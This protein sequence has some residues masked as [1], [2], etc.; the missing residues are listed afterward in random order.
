MNRTIS[1][2]LLLFS[3][4]LSFSSYA[5]PPEAALQ[6]ES[7][8][9]QMKEILETHGIGEVR[10]K[11][12]S[13]AKEGFDLLSYREP[14]LEANSGPL[15]IEVT[16]HPKSGRFVTYANEQLRKTGI[17]FIEYVPVFDEKATA[18][19]DPLP[20]D[21][22][23]DRAWQ[24][25]RGALIPMTGFLAVLWQQGALTDLSSFSFED[26]KLYADLS[27]AM[28]VFML[29]MQFALFSHKWAKLW[30]QDQNFNLQF[31]MLP[32]NAGISRSVNRI[33]KLLNKISAATINRIT[34]S[35]VYNFVVNWGYAL[36]L[37]SVGVFAGQALGLTEHAW[38][39]V[40]LVSKSGVMT[41]AFYLAFG[42]D[43]VA[44]AQLAGRGEVSAH[45]RF[46][47]ETVAVFWNNFWRVASALPGLYALGLGMQLSWGALV[48]LPLYVKLARL[49]KMNEKTRDLFI[50]NSKAPAAATITCEG[51]F[52]P[53]ALFHRQ[54]TLKGMGRV[55]MGA[56]A[57]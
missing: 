25:V 2:F 17:D 14:I 26:K 38:S 50:A 24:K 34:P 37:Y 51:A 45:L 47:I 9:S 5:Q 6:L 33:V 15:K 12:H 21:A 3:S 20:T 40:E 39:V 30:Q 46:K 55:L 28:T 16:I 27:V 35:H 52:S 41:V 48:T 56:T 22:Q 23:A 4:L 32:D 8:T 10:E 18:P 54:Q 13:L 44:M 1:A 11:L 43:Q 36:T 49:E 53:T 19:N 31:G 42:L 29:E 57:K 7:L